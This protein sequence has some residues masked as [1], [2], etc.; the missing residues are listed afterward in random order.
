MRVWKQVYKP[1]TWLAECDRCGFQ[2][3]NTQLAREWTGLRVCKGPG[4]NNCWE[5]RQPQ[6]YLRGKPDRQAPDWSRPPRD[7]PNE[8]FVNEGGTDVRPE[9]L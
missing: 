5:P 6:D 4:T 3:R 1:G 9:D 2:F 8:P 7:P